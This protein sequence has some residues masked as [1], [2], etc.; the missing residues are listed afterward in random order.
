ML[1]IFHIDRSDFPEG[2]RH[3]LAPLESLNVA[4]LLL[5]EEDLASQRLHKYLS[6]VA[7]LA[8]DLEVALR[9]PVQLFQEAVALMDR[10]HRLIVLAEQFEQ[11]VADEVVIAGRDRLEG[12]LRALLGAFLVDKERVGAV[13][14]PG[15]QS[16]QVKLLEKG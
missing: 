12:K 4:A 15:E 3:L 1:H 7:P 9:R 10:T 14:A 5:V 11:V 16:L 13:R 2:A 6:Q 8:V